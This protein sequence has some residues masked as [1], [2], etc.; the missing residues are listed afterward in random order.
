MFFLRAI[1]R[2]GLTIG[3]NSVL[4]RQVGCFFLISHSLFGSLSA[5]HPAFSQQCF[6][7]GGRKTPLPASG[8]L[9]DAEKNGSPVFRLFL[10]ITQAPPSLMCFHNS[11]LWSLTKASGFSH[12][13]SLLLHENFAP[14]LTYPPPGHNNHAWSVISAPHYYVNIDHPPGFPP[15]VP[16]PIKY[17]VV[18]RNCQSL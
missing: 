17:D 16:S 1:L 15:S 18:W 13:S 9:L 14:Q 4:Q 8:V 7:L 10:L 2:E 5:P 12:F 3:A 11:K 6:F